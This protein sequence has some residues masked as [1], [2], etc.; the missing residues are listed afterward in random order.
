MI[1]LSPSSMDDPRCFFCVARSLISWLQLW[2]ILD[3]I[4]TC[5]YQP[6]YQKIQLPS[7]LCTERCLLML[8]R[9]VLPPPPFFPSPLSAIPFFRLLST[10]GVPIS[11]IASLK[12]FQHLS[13]FRS[14]GLKRP[15]AV[16]YFPVP[17]PTKK[18]GTLEDI[19]TICRK[20]VSYCFRNY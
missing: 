10:L 6:I 1:K 19:C 5:N 11:K 16:P 20:K 7:Y 15:S 12:R 2:P 9:S 18:R 4:L 17:R 8:T 13:L 3:S 14:S